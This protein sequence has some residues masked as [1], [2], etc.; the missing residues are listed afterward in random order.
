MSLGTKLT[1][2]GIMLLLLSALPVKNLWDD[3]VLMIAGEQAEGEVVRRRGESKAVD[4]I[5]SDGRKT[6]LARA[7]STKAVGEKLTVTY[8]PEDPMRSKISPLS[9]AL[10]ESLILL[11]IVVPGL[12]C[13]RLGIKYLKA[14]GL[15]D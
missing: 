3:A 2:L 4:Y 15:F 6:Y 5:F 7:I 13:L 14:D 1:A 11:L 10:T 8:D 9:E 12:N